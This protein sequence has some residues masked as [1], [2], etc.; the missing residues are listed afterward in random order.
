M[1][2]ST[3]MLDSPA[4]SLMLDVRD[5]HTY[6]GH[7]HALKGI[8]LSVP[9]GEIVALLARLEIARGYLA[10]AFPLGT[11]GLLIGRKLW[12]RRVR[13][14]RRAGQYPERPA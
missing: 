8:S 11:I 5:V 3:E 6:Y 9:P 1:K 7:V 14:R 2:D 10:L 4:S 13:A 12:R